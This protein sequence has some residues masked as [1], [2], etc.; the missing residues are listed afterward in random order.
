MVFGGNRRVAC[1]P[2]EFRAAAAIL[3]SLL[4]LPR[5]GDKASKG[6]FLLHAEDPSQPHAQSGAAA[7]DPWAEKGTDR[8]CL[9]KLLRSLP[10]ALVSDLTSR[11]TGVLEGK[12]TALAYAS[13]ASTAI[14]TYCLSCDGRRHAPLPRTRTWRR[15]NR[16]CRAP[17]SASTATSATPWP[18]RRSRRRRRTSTSSVA[19]GNGAE[20][21][22]AAPFGRI[23]L[24]VVDRGPPRS[25]RSARAPDPG[26]L[27]RGAAEGAPA[28][29][30]EREFAATLAQR[31]RKVPGG[32]IRARARAAVSL[33]GG[34]ERVVPSSSFYPQE[35]VRK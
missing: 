35:A 26:G 33:I 19:F 13:K 21:A 8:R 23:A 30:A 31:F 22:A 1:R 2:P 29:G 4:V 25:L 16:P 32:P 18:R 17:S 3:E 14:C 6:R 15:T 5:S 12:P 9:L 20:R 24:R 27:A 11:T 34:E 10:T 28:A 7:C